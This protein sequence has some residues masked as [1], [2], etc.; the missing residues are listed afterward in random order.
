[1][2]PAK[3]AS[4]SA[5][6]IRGT[7]GNIYLAWEYLSFMKPS[8]HDLFYWHLLGFKTDLALILGL[9]SSWIKLLGR[10]ARGW[11][12]SFLVRILQA[13]STWVTVSF[14]PF[15]IDCNWPLLSLLRTAIRQFRVLAIVNLQS[16]VSPPCNDVWHGN[17]AWPAQLVFLLSPVQA[18]SQPYTPYNIEVRTSTGHEMPVSIVISTSNAHMDLK[19]W[20]LYTH[21]QPWP[22]KRIPHGKPILCLQLLRVEQYLLSTAQ[23][24]KPPKNTDKPT[25]IIHHISLRM[26]SSLTAISAS[27]LPD[28]NPTAPFCGI[29]LHFARSDGLIFTSNG[30]I[31]VNCVRNVWISHKLTHVH[32]AEHHDSGENGISHRGLVPARTKAN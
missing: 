1:M 9:A 21:H 4:I 8:W 24:P 32:A 29:F 15:N 17:Q 18:V 23:S 11:E 16:M 19:V 28:F 13:L 30:G 22:S 7:F 25:A 5:Q 12:D 10:Y 6:P 26:R 20:S 14:V 2:L 3:V 27:S 31:S